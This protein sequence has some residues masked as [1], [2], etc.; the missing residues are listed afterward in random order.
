MKNEI[1]NKYNELRS[2][3]S[4]SREFKMTEDAIS[5]ILAENNILD[6]LTLNDEEKLNIENLYKSGKSISKINNEFNYGKKRITYVL[7]SKGLMRKRTSKYKKNENIFED[8]NTQEKAYWL[9]FL[10]ADG[11]ISGSKRANLELCLQ[12]K[13]K[14]HIESFKSFMESDA[15]IKRKIAKL[16]GME[17]ISYRIVICSKKIVKDLESKGCI[18]KKSLIL[19]FPNENILPKHLQRHF[20]RGYFDGDGSVVIGNVT[21]TDRVNLITSIVGTKEF[22]QSINEILHREIGINDNKPKL[23]NRRKTF[24]S[25]AYGGNNQNEKIYNFLYNNSTIHLKRKENKFLA[26]LG[27]NT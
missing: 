19:E 23:E 13:D 7:L 6:W 26:V 18:K 27:R 5:R 12:E 1:I 17:Y 21:N 22:L 4:L 15:N 3:K 11:Y 20:I 16:N 2:I 9:G 25:L 8:I 14:H 24:Y 10:Y